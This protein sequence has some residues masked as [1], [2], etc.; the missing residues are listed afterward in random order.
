MEKIKY[1]KMEK[2]GRRGNRKDII[3][4]DFFWGPN[5]SRIRGMRMEQREIKREEIF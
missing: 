3:L 4:I 1:F 2:E 5:L